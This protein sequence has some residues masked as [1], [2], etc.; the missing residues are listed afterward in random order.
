[1]LRERSGERPYNDAACPEECIL[2][3]NHESE[4]WRELLLIEH[5]I[6]TRHGLC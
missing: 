5:R 4:K 3:R 2:P 1:M 6:L